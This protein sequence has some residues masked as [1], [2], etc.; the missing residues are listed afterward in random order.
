[1]MTARN[2]MK[3]RDLR[4]GIGFST[5]AVGMLFVAFA[6][7][8]ALMP[9]QN[10]TFWHL[11][12]GADIWATGQIPRID[13]YSHTFAGAAWPD[14]EWLAQAGMFLAY[15]L[16]GMPGLEI[17]ATALA[18]AASAFVWRL[19]VGSLA[20]RAIVTL[21]GLGLSSW[22]WALRPQVLTLFLLAVLLTMLVRERYRFIP[23]LFLAWANA[24]GGV[25]L[26]GLVLAAAWAAAVLRAWRAR[27]AAGG[28]V[29]AVD[30]R[31][32]RALSIVVP[33][34]GL[35]CAA[36]PLG[37]GIYRFV[38]E[39]TARSIAVHITEWF[40]VLPT[41]GFGVLF[42][43]ATLGLVAAI[44][45]RR[46]AFVAG[47]ASWAEWVTVVTACALLPLAIRSQRNTSPFMLLA[48][49]AASRVLGP[50]FRF[51]TLL[52]RLRRPKPTPST[53]RPA[54]P[55]RPRLNLAILAGMCAIAVALAGW[56]YAFGSDRLGWR[57]IDERALAAARACDG[58]LYNHYDDGGTLIWFLPEKPVFVDGR[59]DPYPLDFLTEF[60]AVEA[61][62]R[63]YRPLLERFHVR[64]A[65]LPLKSPTVAGLDK[66]GWISRYRGDK[67]A[68]LEAPR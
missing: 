32:V 14:H 39:S 25:V 68:V 51:S 56:T 44:V 36:S 19:T 22:F 33:L 5:M 28:A 38:I 42:W 9:A 62:Q 66:E 41:D 67:Y 20:T 52:A 48:I 50:E 60:V 49:P 4:R 64:C 6:L 21:V 18:I 46:G 43:L 24:H 12:A 7:R 59:Q 61:G 15:R 34:A 30:N 26:G 55:D 58:P 35:A 54:D 23:L 8:A 57:P 63:S 45:R 17:G 40:P 31:R 10:D 37:F 16:G 65:F 27:D 2:R 1:M 53:P 29:R 11:R 13:H 47:E 3:L